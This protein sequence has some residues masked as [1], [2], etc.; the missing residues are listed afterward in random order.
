MSPY[1]K[2]RT[3]DKSVVVPT[4]RPV[5]HITC[6][7]NALKLYRQHYNM[8]T[9]QGKST[10]QNELGADA[11]NAAPA[12][13]PDSLAGVVFC[14]VPPSL[15]TGRRYGA[16]IAVDSHDSHLPPRGKI[17]S[18]SKARLLCAE[19]SRGKKKRSRTF[20]SK[21]RKA[22]I[23]REI[24]QDPYPEESTFATIAG[25]IDLG[26]DVVKNWFRNNRSSKITELRCFSVVPC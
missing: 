12:P 23:E 25:R 26:V 19:S 18:R 24:Y 8:F 1:L 16:H 6:C 4:L 5:V 11:V 10:I 22:M 7:P 17:D 2:N 3:F 20:I 9:L 13:T 14:T 21:A 15:D